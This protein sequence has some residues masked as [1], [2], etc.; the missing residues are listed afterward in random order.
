MRLSDQLLLSLEDKLFLVFSNRSHHTKCSW[1]DTWDSWKEDGTSLDEICKV[2]DR[3]VKDRP[4]WSMTGLSTGIVKEDENWG[5]LFK[6]KVDEN[7]HIILLRKGE[8]IASKGIREKP[9]VAPSLR[10]WKLGQKWSW[11]CSYMINR[12]AYFWQFV[13]TARST[14]WKRDDLQDKYGYCYWLVGLW[15]MV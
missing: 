12:F 1:D 13:K 6:Q 9:M 11:R 10:M 14:Y 4:S 3:L 5:L 15:I 2:S 7:Q 8:E